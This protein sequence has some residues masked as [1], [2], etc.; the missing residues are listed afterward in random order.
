MKQQGELL[1]I[2]L[3]LLIS[4]CSSAINAQTG[5]TKVNILF[6]ISDDQSFAHTSFYGCKFV[7]T[8]AFDRIASE[9][10]YFSNCFAGSPGCAPSRSCIVTGRYHWQNEQSGQ[11]ASSWMKKS[12]INNMYPMMDCSG[13][14]WKPVV[15]TWDQT[16]HCSMEFRPMMTKDWRYSV[17]SPGHFRIAGKSLLACVGLAAMRIKGQTLT[18]FSMVALRRTLVNLR[19]VTFRPSCNWPID[20]TRTI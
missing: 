11:H 4:I 15:Q 7:E 8:P 6:A 10:I 18:D 2:T 3:I 9:G 20:R 16:I 5:P 14:R 12:F 13:A 19:K 1:R 17:K